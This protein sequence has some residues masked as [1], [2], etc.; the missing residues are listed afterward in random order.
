MRAVQAR[1]PGHL[2]LVDLPEPRPASDEAIIEIRCIGI[3]GSDLHAYNGSHPFVTYPR[4]LGHECSGVLVEAPRGGGLPAEMKVGDGV[5]IEPYIHCRQCHMCR[6]GRP[7][8][9]LQLKVLGV[10]VDGTM[11]ERMAVRADKLH[12]VPEGLSLRSAALAEPLGVGFHAAGRGRIAAGQ[13]VFVIGSGT[14]GR[15]VLAAAKQAGAFVAVSER[16]RR[17]IEAARRLGADLALDANDPGGMIESLNDWTAGKGPDVVVEAA[18]TPETIQQAFDLARPGGTVVL[19]GMTNLPVRLTTRPI[20]AKELDVYAS[21]NSTGVLDGLL[22][23]LAGGRID[24]DSF[25]SHEIRLA[26]APQAIPDM[27]ENPDR[28]LKVLV[29]VDFS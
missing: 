13:K 10:H 14:I 1:Q 8:A 23:A 16:I 2:Q 29:R 6:A 25:I 4:V 21:R 22:A 17:R 11:T 5:V 9:C 3:C 15:S 18:G 12:R 26:D 24:A 19:V 20:M 28:Y 7:N 27:C